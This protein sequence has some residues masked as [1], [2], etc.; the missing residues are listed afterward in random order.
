[1]PYHATQL[2]GPAASTNNEVD[3]PTEGQ[4]KNAHGARELSDHGVHFGAI[5]HGGVL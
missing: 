2:S 5:S 3:K 1:M 4:F